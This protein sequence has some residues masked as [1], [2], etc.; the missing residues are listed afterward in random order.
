MM[1]TVKWHSPTRRHALV[2]IYLHDSSPRHYTQVSPQLRVPI[3]KASVHTGDEKGTQC[4]REQ[5]DRLVPEGYEQDCLY[6]QD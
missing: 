5:C 4:L 1:S 3:A 6:L 2:E